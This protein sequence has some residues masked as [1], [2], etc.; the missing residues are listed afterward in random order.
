MGRCAAVDALKMLHVFVKSYL[1]RAE[2]A[3][4]PKRHCSRCGDGA[5]WHVDGDGDSGLCS[6]ARGYVMCTCFALQIQSLFIY[7]TRVHVC[8]CVCGCLLGV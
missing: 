8:V 7:S 2:F 6:D 1:L 5:K 3:S 4:S